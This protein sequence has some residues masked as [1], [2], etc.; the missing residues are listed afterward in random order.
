MKNESPVYITGHQHPDTDSVASAIA[1]AFFKRANGIKSI[2]CRLGDLNNE[3]EYLLKRFGF[4]KPLLLKD[5]RITLADLELDEPVSITPETT[6]RDAIS[7]M[8]EYERNSFAVTHEDGTIAGYVSKSDLANIGLGDTAAEIEL[9]KQTTVEEIAETIDGTIVY[10]DDQV[11]YNGKTSIVALNETKVDNYNAEDRIVIVGNDTAAQKQL[12]EKGAGML[13]VVWSNGIKDEVKKAAAEYHCPI[14]L[15]GHGAMNTSRYL[16]FAPPVRLI[17]TDDPIT[18]RSDEFAE[19]AGNKMLKTRFRSYP[20]VNEKKVLCGYVSRFHIL[21]HKNKKIILVDHNEFSQSVRNVEKAQILEVIDHHRINDFA[22]TQPV[23]FRNEI[24]GSTATIIATMFRE[25]QIPIP[26]NLAGLLLGAL[27]SDTLVFQSPTTTRKDIDTANILAALADL[28]IDTFAKE[29]FT[30]SA[31]SI[32]QSIY[33]MIVQDIKYYDIGGIRTMISQTIVPSVEKMRSREIEISR[34]MNRLYEKKELDLLVV[35]FTSV[36]EDGS[37]FYTV[38]EKADKILDVY[39]DLPGE[40]H[41]VQ[42]GVFSRKKQI[43]PAINE[44]LEF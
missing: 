23:S 27:L 13:I 41:S 5:A 25:N 34:D 31:S 20:V 8:H 7:K 12:I 15:S 1:Y 33:E 6:V 18:F 22:T 26:A 37:I 36:L 35:C 19:D 14:I 9:L 24:I 29:M 44:A 32:N 38:G 40:T 30:A 11:H 3:T 42:H 28:D 16:F 43:V 10:N 4:E 2:P 17:M 21:N 39:P